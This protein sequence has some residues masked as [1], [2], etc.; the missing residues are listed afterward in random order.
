MAVRTASVERRV[1]TESLR[2]QGT[3][4][5]V[6]RATISARLPG[7]LDALYVDTGDAVTNGQPLFQ[8]DKANLENAVAVERENLRVAEASVAEAEAA[9]RQAETAFEKAT[10]DL[11]R[12]RRL[13]EE[14][15]AVSKDAF[16]RMNLAY[17]QAATGLE[18]AKAAVTLVAARKQQAATALQIAEKNLSDSRVCAPFD[19]I[20]TRRL[21]QPG[22]FVGAGVPVLAMEDPRQLEVVLTLSEQWFPR[23]EPGRTR[24]RIISAGQPSIETTVSVKSP[25]VHPIAR[26]V[27]VKAP[28]PA[29]EGFAP[30]MICDAIVVFAQRE[31][32]GVPAEA[33]GMRQG[34]SVVFIV[35]NETAHQRDVQP[36][37][38]D[39]GYVDLLD[40]ESLIGKA[41]IVEGQVFLND[42]DPIRVTQAEPSHN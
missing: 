36:G 3:I 6:H 17:K 22:E 35:D 12:F 23:I 1:F 28:L 30:G 2:V 7:A 37:L 41:V 14:D 34:R 4:M 20:V 15:R 18:R 40:G 8:T 11:E 26:T 31:G 9:L 27:E 24:V 32:W 10:L 19:G 21:C 13:Y 25:S 42:G 29:A 33:V 16:E 39:D 5:A 38:R